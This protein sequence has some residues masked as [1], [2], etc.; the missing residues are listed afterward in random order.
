MTDQSPPPKKKP[1]PGKDAAGHEFAGDVGMAESISGPRTAAPHGLRPVARP[2]PPR[3]PSAPPGPPGPPPP[4]PPAA[5]PPP[6]VGD[7]A[8]PGSKYFSSSAPPA[9]R[10]PKQ[11]PRTGR[12]RDIDSDALDSTIDE[13]LDDMARRRERSQQAA[14]NNASAPEPE[15][16]GAPTRKDLDAEARP[17]DLEGGAP[18]VVPRRRSQR[19][20]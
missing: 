17:R 3:P 11:L 16:T 1:Q 13:S 10:S 15:R 12:D 18:E 2:R 20:M 6:P 4:A 14:D 19:P 9:P 7:P 5:R 8:V